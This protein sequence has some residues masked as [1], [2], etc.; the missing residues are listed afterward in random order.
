[1]DNVFEQEVPG[2]GLSVDREIWTITMDCVHRAARR[3]GS[4]GRRPVYPDRLIVAMFLWAT[5]HDRCLSWACD[6]C[7]YNSLFRPRSPL[8]SV[9]Q[10]T[11]RIKTEQC[12]QIL[13]LVHID[14]ASRGVTPSLNYIDGKPLTVSP[15]SKDR[16][17]GRGHVSGGYAKGY[18]LHAYITQSRRIAV[19]S[20]TPL[21]TDEKTTAREVL[22]PH[23]PLPADPLGLLLADKGYDA[24]PLYK[25]LGH[26]GHTLM[27]PLRGQQF[28]SGESH[29]PKSLSEMGK[30]RREVLAGWTHTPRLMRYVME[31]R[32]NAEGVFSVLA[33]SLG[34]HA[35]PGFVR[36][37]HRVRNFVGGKI[38]LY[39]ARLL[40]KERL[41][42]AAA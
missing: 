32:N 41:A 2:P 27:T 13:Q 37:I 4:S 30:A 6:R 14:L 1:M 33:L 3:V 36:R 20:V 22:L 24:A 15:V 23:L 8:P 25:A 17:A 29:Q 10:F 11:R 18:K 5:W 35:L 31:Q 19:W 38:I 26:R 16:D 42:A 28:I 12:R 39:H 34:L 7:H 21:N 40:A 9:S